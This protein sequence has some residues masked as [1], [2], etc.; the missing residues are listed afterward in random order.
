MLL[1]CDDRPTPRGRY[2][3]SPKLHPQANAAR[4]DREHAG[5]AR[6][7][8]RRTRTSAVCFNRNRE[9]SQYV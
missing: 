2:R 9:D 5:P 1:M 6:Q 7:Y 4:G 8:A 3:L